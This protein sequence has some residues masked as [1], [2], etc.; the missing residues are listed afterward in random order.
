MPHAFTRT[1]SLLYV[2]ALL[3]CLLLAVL[4][5][6]GTA[7][8]ATEVTLGDLTLTGGYYTVSPGEEGDPSEVTAVAEAE[9]GDDYLYYDAGTTTLTVTGQVTIDGLSL[10]ID[11]P[12]LTLKGEGS[13]TIAGDGDD[14]TV[15]GDLNVAITG[16]VEITNDN[17]A[18]V[19]GD[20]T[21]TEAVNVTVTVTGVY[22]F[23]AVRGDVAITAS[24]DVSISNARGPAVDGDL[25][26]SGADNLTVS[27]AGGGDATVGGDVEVTAGGNVTISNTGDYVAIGGSLTVSGAADVTVSGGGL[28]IVCDAVTL[29]NLSGDVEIINASGSAIYDDLT[30]N[31]AVNV[32]VSGGNVCEAVCGEAEITASGDVTLTATSSSAV[33]GDLTVS[34][35]NNLTVSGG[36]DSAICG[37]A[38]LSNLSGDVKITNTG[39]MAVMGALTVSGAV[40]VTVSGGGNAPTVSGAATIT[41]SG[42]V[43]ITAAGHN[44]VGRKLTVN[45]AR[46]VTVSNVANLPAIVGG[47]EIS[48]SGDVSITSD[49]QIAVLGNLTVTQANKVTVSGGESFPAVSGWATISA[50][51]DVSITAQAYSAVGDKLTVKRAR[52]V[53]VSNTGFNHEYGS[54]GS[55][56]VGNGAEISAGGDV[57]ITSDN[58]IAVNGNLT[59]TQAN[60]V[61]VSSGGEYFQAVSGSAIITASDDVSMSGKGAPTVGGAATIATSGDVRITNADNIAVSGKLTV[62]QARNVTVSSGLSFGA[63]AIANGAEIT[64]QGDVSISCSGGMAVS[65]G[66]LLIH[67]ANNVTL[68]GNSGAPTVS[69]ADITA[70]GD[71]KITNPSGSAANSSSLETDALLIRSANNVTLSGANSPTVTGPATITA[72][73]DVKLTNPSNGVCTGAAAITAGGDIFASGTNSPTFMGIPTQ[74]SAQ[75]NLIVLGGSGSAYGVLFVDPD[76]QLSS[77]TGLIVLVNSAKPE[78]NSITLYDGTPLD[79]VYGG[80][81]GDSGLTLSAPPARTTAYTAGGGYIIATPAAGD[82]RAA[83]DLYKVNIA[84]SDGPAL[85]LPAA[86]AELADVTLYGDSFLASAEGHS[87]SGGGSFT[88]SSNATLTL[89][90]LDELAGLEPGSV[91]N[92]GV[93]ILPAG[94]TPQQIKALALT[95]GGKIEVG[96]RSYSNSGAL[97]KG[98]GSASFIIT[99]GAGAGGSIS[100]AGRVSVKRGGDQSFTITPDSGYVIDQVLADGQSVGAVSSYSFENV[101]KSHTL[102]ATFAPAAWVNPYTDV[103]S[104]DWFYSYV[105]ELSAAG[106][107]SGYPDGTFRPAGTVTY[108]E[109]LKLVLLAAG[110][111]EQAPANGHWAGGYLAQ[112]Q[113][114]GLL[115]PVA[116][117]NAP[118]D[119]LTIAQLTAKALKLPAPAHGSAFSDTADEAVRSLQEAKI[120]EGSLNAAGQRLYKPAD[121]ITRAELTTIVRRIGSYAE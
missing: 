121:S 25:T 14:P 49:S 110:Y 66:A 34:G 26:V 101:R 55:P 4:L 19:G 56:A 91:A 64:A 106:V 96:G 7:L 54:D 38:T 9:K 103:R 2:A 41:A 50:N 1:R 31:G 99:A 53:T 45:Q 68:S 69:N 10:D 15:N 59:V 100:P 13:L 5:T 107:V 105:A 60:K 29:T 92:N 12:G 97:L 62:N 65:D 75:D 111:K 89:N 102:T 73:G 32:T 11:G 76:P 104:D 78:Q 118:I 113:T 93:L 43:S 22:G 6:P 120:V 3:L 57:S 18:A 48:A 119:R 70:R 114:Q 87:L 77:A 67:D 82:R 81:V 88:I 21:V 98:G 109:A 83:L 44:A 94:V 35:A 52:N 27:G 63:P 84:A 33:E 90:S 42:D 28:Y 39:G 58:H 74:L 36:G 95:G 46:K 115:G 116:D 17:Q 24:G 85:A 37:S 80:E 20:L 79:A 117:L 8:A 16:D 108:G 61:T 47:A 86:P 72:R 71:V 112:A 23:P 30:V 51:G 40:N